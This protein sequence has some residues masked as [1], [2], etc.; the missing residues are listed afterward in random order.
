MN[1]I[2][3]SD[4]FNQSKI[5]DILKSF[6]ISDRAVKDEPEF[7]NLLLLKS[8][9]YYKRLQAHYIWLVLQT[10]INKSYLSSLQ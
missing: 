9:I 2:F 6:F 7:I 1:E 4:G 10:H 3:N 8:I 5:L